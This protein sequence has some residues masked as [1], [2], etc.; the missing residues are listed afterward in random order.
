MNLFTLKQQQEQQE[1][2]AIFI[3]KTSQAFKYWQKNVNTPAGLQL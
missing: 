1:N 2:S 3:V